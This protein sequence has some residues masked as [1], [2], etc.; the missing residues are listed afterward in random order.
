MISIFQ[1]DNI[2]FLK[3]SSQELLKLSRVTL[4]KKFFV[5][6]NSEVLNRGKLCVRKGDLVLRGQTLTLG[7]G[8]I[9]SIHSPTSGRIIDVINNYIFFLDQFFAVVIVESDGRDLWIS[10]TP[11]CNYTQF[12]SKKLI[13]LIYHSGILG[14]SGSGFSTSKKL[15]CAVGKVHTLVVNA[16]ESE[17]CVTS[18]DCLIQ[19]FSKEIIDGCKILIWILKIK[20]I[21]I[22]VSEEKII[23][24]NVL[25]KSV[26]N[27]KD[28]E[29]LKV[30]NKYPS[31]SSKK[32]IQILFN[33]E[34]PQ[35]KHAIDLGIIMYNVAT[36][37]AIKKAIL[38]GE[39]L[40]ERVITLYGDKFLPSKNV[41]VRIGTPISHLMKIYKLNE[42]TLKVNIG[43]PITGL[44]IRNFNFSVL[45]TN[46]C[47]MF[48]S[49][50]NNELNNFEEKNCIRCA[51]CSY[52]CPM[53]LLPEQLY[54]YSKHSNHE[55][56]QIYNIQDC[57]ECGIC[58]QVCP[59]DIP[60]MSY[61]RREKKQISIAKFKNYQIKKFKNLFLLRKQR[62][63]N[64][65]SRKKNTIVSQ[66]IALNKF[67]FKV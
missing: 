35:G 11:I 49:I 62:L 52:S 25:K 6:I 39:P 2:L 57:I 22:V 41:L 48:V 29:L 63:N 16:V 1:V 56:T 19:N 34:I 26:I 54:W 61:Y 38:D 14:L 53:N 21:L 30:K 28:F 43:G 33:K 12:S 51:A 55:K 9:V 50:Q 17:P 20:K 23:A 66:Y 40:T 45:K 3:K 60:L 10:R 37:F 59:S 4:P 42:K 18:D 36:V 46:N 5:L 64:L 32:L 65:N 47:I 27:L 31:G 44:L 8:N 7:C 13:N 24:F 15:Q 58:E 67:N